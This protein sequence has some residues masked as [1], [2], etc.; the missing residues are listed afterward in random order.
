MDSATE[1]LFTKTI[2]NNMTECLGINSSLLLAS[3]Q[4]AA[5][6]QRKF[7]YGSIAAFFGSFDGLIVAFP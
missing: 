5:R 2:N 7:T 4:L 3:F 6:T 1:P